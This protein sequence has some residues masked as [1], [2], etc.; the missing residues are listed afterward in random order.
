MIKRS[1]CSQRC[2]GR[3]A[4]QRRARFG[5]SVAASLRRL[6]TGARPVSRFQFARGQLC[7][8]FRA[9]RRRRS[10]GL[11]QHHDLEVAPEQLWDLLARGAFQDNRWR[12]A[13][14]LSACHLGIR[15]AARDRAAL[16]KAG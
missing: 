13:P 12:T 11:E 3:R 1:R 10:L 14:T 6:A 4:A 8:A 15:P 2:A 5:G 7:K 9:K 16:G